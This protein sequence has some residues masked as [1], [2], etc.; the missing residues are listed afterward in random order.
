[1]YVLDP[2]WIKNLIDTTP[3]QKMIIVAF[4]FMVIGIVWIRKMVRI[5]V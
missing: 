4:V 5:D 3:G 2:N 1:M